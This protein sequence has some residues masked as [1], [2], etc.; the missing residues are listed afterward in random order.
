MEKREK[1][2]GSIV[3]V[4]LLL[5]GALSTFNFASQ[6]KASAGEVVQ[7]NKQDLFNSAQ[8][9]C[10]SKKQESLDSIVSG[11]GSAEQLGRVIDQ[12][13]TQDGCY[14]FVAQVILDEVKN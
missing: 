10:A 11:A 8:A 4:L 7:G 13:S 3:L 9:L 2:V 5:F 6:P 1:V 12:L 14:K